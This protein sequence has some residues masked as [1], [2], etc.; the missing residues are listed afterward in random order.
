[1]SKKA[2]SYKNLDAL[3]PIESLVDE[4][5]AAVAD[6]NRL[7]SDDRQINEALAAAGGIVAGGTISFAGL[8][9][10]GSVV[11]LSAPGIASGL[12]AAGSIIGKGM[13]AGISVLATPP[14]V[15][16][17]GGYALITRRNKKKLFEK[18]EILM[19]EVLK[20]HNAIIAEIKKQI[21]KT[22]K[23]LCI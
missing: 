8:Y 22:M 1:M 10:G 19:Q 14:I 6:P 7:S 20:K 23:G 13:A 12:A 9:F 16:G 11:G 21:K 18:K 2:V 4:A 3:K 15:L 5:S 17:L